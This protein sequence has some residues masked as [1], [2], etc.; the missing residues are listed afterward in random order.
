MAY[1]DNSG[2]IILDAVLTDEG[3]RRLALGNGSFN[4]A[5][6]ALAD[7]E[8]DY[9]LYD[10]TPSSGSAYSDLRIL[11]LPIFEAFTN[12]LSSVKSKLITYADT[13]L[14]YLPVIKL[15]TKNNNATT[16][17]ADGPV[18]GYYVSVDSST[19]QRIDRLDGQA[20][21]TGYRFAQPGAATN[22]MS[23]IVDQGIDNSAVNLAYLANGNNQQ[24][25]LL[26][27]AYMVELDNRLLSI[28]PTAPDP[29]TN[30]VTAA[31]PS[32]IDDDNIASYFFGFNEGSNYFAR[33]PGGLNGVAEPAF[34][35][36]DT[37]NAGRQ[38]V[39]SMI[40]PTNTTGLQGSRLVL[41]LQSQLSVQQSDDLFTTL[42]GSTSITINGEASTFKFINTSLR[43]TGFNTGYRIEIPLKLLKYSA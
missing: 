15:N 24:S 20:T 43:I 37:Q 11:Q 29:H 27:R 2:D 23:I 9:S 1:L 38:M 6:F 26:E 8:I 19:T 41:G 16:T 25:M 21:A 39:N 42:G 32:F 18:G 5:K 13:T 30:L 4:I 10:K 33:Q 35:Y 36:V 28:M 22:E 17:D 7:D 34:R 12:N 40:G 14:L 3:R 31:R